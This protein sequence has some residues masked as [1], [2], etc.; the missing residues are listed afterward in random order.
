MI[1]IIACIAA[2]A[3]SS[4]IAAAFIVALASRSEDRNWSLGLPPHS[5]VEAMARRIVRFDADSIDWPRS[6]ARVQAEQAYRRQFPETLDADTTI[7]T[8]PR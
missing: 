3:V 2:A 6:K 5:T 7:V 1:V 8:P 4:P